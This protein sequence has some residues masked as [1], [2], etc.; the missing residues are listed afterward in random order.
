MGDTTD[1]SA[2]REYATRLNIHRLEDKMDRLDSKLRMIF[3]TIV[4]ALASLALKD[5]F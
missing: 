2:E 4:A 3:V 5:I 1:H